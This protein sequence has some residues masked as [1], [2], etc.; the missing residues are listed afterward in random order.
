T[1]R[2]QHL[3][4]QH[5]IDADLHVVLGYA[6]L[7]GNIQRLFLQRMAIGNALDEGNQDMEAGLDGAAVT[8]QVLHD[9]GAS[10]WHHHGS[11]HQD[12]DHQHHQGDNYIQ[13]GFH[14]CYSC[15]DKRSQDW[16]AA[17]TSSVSPS[18]LAMMASVPASMGTSS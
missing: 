7:L 2:I 6:D 4:I 1:A 16:G 14:V 17:R 13:T 18:T 9:I 5:A 10:L 8:P 15:K 3:Q 11:L 12:D